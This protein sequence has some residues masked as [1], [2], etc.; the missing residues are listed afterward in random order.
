VA[1]TSEKL[2]LV[3]NDDGYKAWGLRV[4]I[5]IAKEFGRVVAVS[6]NEGQSGMSHAITVK[7]PLR[8]YQVEK[9]DNVEIYAC[10]GTPVDCVKLALNKILPRKPDLVLS[11][12]NHGSNSSASVFYSGTIAAAREGTINQIPSIGFSYCDYSM[13]PDYTLVKKIIRSIIT[14]AFEKNLS[15]QYCLNVNIPIADE[16]NLKGIRICRQT[17]GFWKEEFEKRTDPHGY[18]YYWLTGTFVNMEPDAEDTDEWA[19]KN[20]YVSVVPIHIDATA[21]DAIDELKKWKWLNKLK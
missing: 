6:T 11:G 7:V 5:D 13:N 16:K 4:L 1:A 10:T 15:D 2:I 14:E 3:T 17:K 20:N 21:F 9:Q 18:D 19:L 12:I 8:L